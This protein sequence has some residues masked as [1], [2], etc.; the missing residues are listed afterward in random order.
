M[1][2]GLRRGALVEAFLL[3]ALAAAAPFLV[4]VAAAFSPISASATVAAASSGKPSAPVGSTQ[5]PAPASPAVGVDPAAW[6][7]Q[8]PVR[9]AG[10]RAFAGQP[11]DGWFAAAFD[12]REWVPARGLV[13]PR[14]ARRQPESTPGD[15]GMTLLDVRPTGALLLRMRFDVP[16]RDRVRVLGLRVTYRDGFVAFLNG[17]E[18]ARSNLAATGTAGAVASAPHGAEPETIYL[19]ILPGRHELPLRRQDNVL[20]VAVVSAPGRM[21]DEGVA[22]S[23]RIELTAAAGVRLVRGPYLVAPADGV[24]SV[25]WETDLPAS[26]WVDV[27]TAGTPGPPRRFHVGEVAT[28]QV[29][30]LSGLQV[31]RRY[32]YVVT[33]DAR[34][35]PAARGS[36]VAAGLAAPGAPT[37]APVVAEDASDRAQSSPAVFEAAPSATMP[38][39]FA[40]YGDMRAPGHAAHADVA[41]ALVKER[42]PLVLNTGDLVATGSEESAWQKYF[43]I[44]AGLGAIAPIVPALGNHDASRGGVG[45]PKAWRLFGMSQAN[46]NAYYTS[47]DWGGAHFVILDTNRVSGAQSAWLERD[48]AAARRR[49][50]RAIFAFCHESP[51]SHGP[52]GGSRVVEQKLASLLAAAGVDVLFSGHDHLYERGIA[53]TPRGRLPYVVTG[54]GGAPLYNP[55]CTLGASGGP[56]GAAPCPPSVKALVRTYHYVMVELAG[57]R[58]RLCPKRPDGSAVEP[59]V[60]LTARGS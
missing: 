18:I 34:P 10:V 2:L 52:H 28:R 53:V 26:G 42:P 23:G 13:L 54:G 27:E 4:P 15:S 51:W 6:D 41:A 16:E 40:V 24:V 8:V 21:T 44:T 55:T 59:C 46:P 20:A 9:S 39:R 57:S 17:V 11:P 31:G 47:F 25:A 36:G 12:D 32:R 33:A 7:K 50:V 37:A 1:K 48:L 19:P 60:E 58:L 22:P 38:L 5:S 35:K 30:R 29:V 43:E 56:A 3:V 49:R 14:S 45:S